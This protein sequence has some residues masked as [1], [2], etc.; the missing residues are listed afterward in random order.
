MLDLFKSSSKFS[1]CSLFLFLPK[2]T[3]LGPITGAKVSKNY[4][5]FQG[6]IRRFLFP[7]LYWI[8]IRILFNKWQVS[9]FSTEN[10]KCFIP[11]KYLSKAFFNFQLIRLISLK[12]VKKKKIDFL[13]YYR[14]HPNKF[15]KK[16]IN[17]I[18]QISKNFSVFIV[19]DNFNNSKVKNLGII[20]KK[21]LSYYLS[22]AKMTISSDE[23][24]ISNFNIECLNN[25]VKVILR[26]DKKFPNFLK[27]YNFFKIKYYKQDFENTKIIRQINKIEKNNKA[28]NKN[29]FI[30]KLKKNIDYYFNNFL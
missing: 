13:I 21:K 4:Y 2:K 19:G 26:T 20:N 25:G 8:S 10:L 16:T 30:D 18:N 23:N 24:L 6:I 27:S 1:L 3:I 5:S 11:N 15:D 28:K 7:L 22:N 29:L 17:L 14:N 9:L 12:K